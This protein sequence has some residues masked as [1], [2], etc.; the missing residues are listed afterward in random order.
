MRA[1]LATI[2]A[3]IVPLLCGWPPMLSASETV[4]VSQDLF[5]PAPSAP[6]S[7]RAV[8]SQPQ[9]PEPLHPSPNRPP[10]QGQETAAS[11]RPC[12]AQDPAS[13][14]ASDAGSRN[15]ETP[16]TGLLAL[17]IPK[18]QD[19]DRAFLEL[20]EPGTYRI[21]RGGPLRSSESQRDARSRDAF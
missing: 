14:R 3:L 9:F 17:L 10:D 6:S 1:S 4:P 13:R 16:V 21:T 5:S 11:A 2:T 19:L 7:G 8:V 20:V 15:P 18:Q 12:P